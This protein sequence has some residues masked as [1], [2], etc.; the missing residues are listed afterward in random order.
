MGKVGRVPS[1]ATAAIACFE[2]A[3]RS[4]LAPAV[5]PTLAPLVGR[6]RAGPQ[7]VNQHRENPQTA[8]AK[9][10]GKHT[11]TRQE[12]RPRSGIERWGARTKEASIRKE[13]ES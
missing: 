6:E 9:T 5:R 8:A 2:K 11:P 12:H 10:K 13:A 1:R 3:Q 7:M 4:G